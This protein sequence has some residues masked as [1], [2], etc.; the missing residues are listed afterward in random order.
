MFDVSRPFGDAFNGILYVVSLYFSFEKFPGVF[1]RFDLFVEGD[2]GFFLS[3][4]RFAGV[5]GRFG[6][7]LG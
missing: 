4:E 5:L 7:F 1:G 3:V 2:Q 6:L